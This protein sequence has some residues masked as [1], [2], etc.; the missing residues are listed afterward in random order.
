MLFI[1]NLNLALKGHFFFL[2][3]HVEQ[4]QNKAEA[5]DWTALA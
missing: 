2:K 3:D 1:L 5:G 4:E